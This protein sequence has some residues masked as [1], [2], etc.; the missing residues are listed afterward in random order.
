MS[1]QSVA[2]EHPGAAVMRLSERLAN[3]APPSVAATLAARQPVAQRPSP[4]VAAALAASQAKAAKAARQAMRP[5]RHR[6]LVTAFVE[7][8][9]AACSFVPYAVVALGLRLLMAFVFFVSGQAKVAGPQIPLNV[10]DVSLSVTLPTQVKAETFGLFL[11]SYSSM[12]LPP[13]AA[14]YL[15][16]YAEFLL[17]VFLVLGLATRF[18]A[19]GLL[20]I[21]ALLQLY[22][23]PNELW[24][25]HIYWF[26]ILAVLM[27]RGPGELSIDHIIRY[28]SRR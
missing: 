16:S 15:V 5:Q 13:V 12:P 8:F 22:V 27:T 1:D 19:L 3:L 11:S 7:S 26:A 2:N 23:M 21:T 4:A 17:P 24:T 20:M 10:Y 25:A 9:V 6:T 18:A 14:A 28:V